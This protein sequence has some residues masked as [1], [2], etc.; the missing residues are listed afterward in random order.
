V[1]VHTDCPCCTS[2]LSTESNN[3]ETRI[4]GNLVINFVDTRTMISGKLGGKTMKNLYK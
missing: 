3:G 1:T 2:K 4:L